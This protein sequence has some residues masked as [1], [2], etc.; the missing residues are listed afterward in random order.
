MSPTLFTDAL[1][2]PIGWIK[3]VANDY[4]ICE[5][6]FNDE[7]PTALNSN[8]LTQLAKEQL[9]MYLRGELK[10]FDLPLEPAGTEFQKKVWKKLGKIEYGTS[11]SYSA[12]SKDTPLAIRAMASANGKNKIL[13]V[14]PCHRV[15]G[16]K[17]KLVGYAGGLA[18]KQWLLDL[19]QKRSQKGQAKLEL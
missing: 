19:E 3:I 10:I 9:H 6:S 17:G 8:K 18:R 14:I 12:L 2:S 16:N 5:I 11:I 1:E 13:I 15:I 4:A 7:R